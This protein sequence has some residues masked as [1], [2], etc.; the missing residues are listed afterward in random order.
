[1][2]SS[3]SPLTFLPSAMNMSEF[4]L[5][6]VVQNDRVL[7][8]DV[9]KCEKACRDTWYKSLHSVQIVRIDS[10]MLS[11]WC[12]NS[13]ELYSLFRMSFNMGRHVDMHVT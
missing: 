6:A 2:L 11:Q 10:R 5:V 8:A 13:T 12:M 9:V 7:T 3:V 1:M 4:I